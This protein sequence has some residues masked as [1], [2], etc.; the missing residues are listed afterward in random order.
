MSLASSPW[1]PGE[2]AIGLSRNS[3]KACFS[4]QKG[5][6]T[7]YF[8][9]KKIIPISSSKIILFCFLR[10]QKPIP[11]GSPSLLFVK[12]KGQLHEGTV[13]HLWFGLP[14]D[15]ETEHRAGGNWFI[16][17]SLGEWTSTSHFWKTLWL[18]FI[19]IFLGEEVPPERTLYS[20]YQELA[21]VFLD[22]QGISSLYQLCREMQQGTVSSME[23][24]DLNSWGRPLR[25]PQ[26][27]SWI[28]ISILL[29]QHQAKIPL[30]WPIRGFYQPRSVVFSR[31]DYFKCNRHISHWSIARGKPA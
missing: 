26:T 11:A 20:V 18:W 5:V 1:C 22:L 23:T 24:A 29:L 4:V 7:F 21:R 25:Q 14:T 8:G 2:E 19:S 31:L 13:S 3:Q 28:Q 6:L 12:Q 15:P 9:R 16:C 10:C 27:V 17:K 30:P